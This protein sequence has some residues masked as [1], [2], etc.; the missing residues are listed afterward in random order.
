MFRR[1]RCRN[2]AG[3]QGCKSYF[4]SLSGRAHYG[5][6]PWVK[7]LALHTRVFM[8]IHRTS[9]SCSFLDA[10]NWR[11][12]FFFFACA[13][14]VG[15]LH[16]HPCFI[17]QLWQIRRLLRSSLAPE[18]GGFQPFR[19]CT[20]VLCT[21]PPFRI[22][23]SRITELHIIGTHELPPLPIANTDWNIIVL[24]ALATAVPLHMDQ[25]AGH[26]GPAPAEN[27]SNN[28]L[29]QNFQPPLFILLTQRARE[30][31]DWKEATHAHQCFPTSFR[32]QT[33]LDP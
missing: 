29:F 4:T 32:E 18:N 8:F 22:D 14:P 24:P 17:W 25:C 11:Q 5:F 26:S 27:N 13:A 30:Q 28:S 2:S 3:I 23:H 31:L 12:A 9:S 10:W 15:L 20:G 7:T 19:G 16:S 33:F 6:S 21:I 1:T